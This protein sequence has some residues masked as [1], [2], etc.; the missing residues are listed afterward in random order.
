MKLAAA[1]ASLVLA[2]APATVAAPVPTAPD[3]EPVALAR[4]LAAE[5]SPLFTQ[6]RL[7]EATMDV[8]E[9]WM[10]A[11][12]REGVPD[13]CPAPPQIRIAPLDLHQFYASL[14]VGAASV[15]PRVADADGAYAAG[16]YDTRT[17]KSLVAFYG[18]PAERAMQA[19][20][21]RFMDQMANHSLE[22]AEPLMRAPLS[23]SQ[24]ASD[25]AQA[26]DDMGKVGGAGETPEEAA[27][28]KTQ[29]GRAFA[30]GEA[31]NGAH[32]PTPWPEMIAAAE[33][34]YCHRQ[35]CDE[36]VRGFFADLAAADFEKIY[37]P[38]AAAPDDPMPP[39]R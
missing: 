10:D 34:D 8:Y 2:T 29:A 13:C 12:L 23:G 39:L 20:R 22:M 31:A 25:V 14:K 9:A 7:N 5:F 36:A 11:R 4:Q 33:D 24:A 19:R 28:A 16:A 35:P 38:A 3:A 18:A 32:A 30:L 15:G 37:D 27:F 21:T 26:A 17:L 1:F 6:T